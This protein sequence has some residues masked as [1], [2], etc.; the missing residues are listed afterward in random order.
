MVVRYVW[1]LSSRI[2]VAVVIDLVS[3]DLMGE[4]YTNMYLHEI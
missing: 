1:C 4:I 2:Y 3:I